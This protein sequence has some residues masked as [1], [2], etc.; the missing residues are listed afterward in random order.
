MPKD[1]PAEAQAFLPFLQ[2]LPKTLFRAQ[3]AYSNR[4][5]VYLTPDE[6]ENLP[7]PYRVGDTYQVSIGQ[8]GELELKQS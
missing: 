4:V 5:V 1:A 6:W 3:K 8:T 2:A 7:A